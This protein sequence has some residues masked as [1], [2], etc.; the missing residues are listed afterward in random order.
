MN[1]QQFLGGIAL[2]SSLACSGSSSSSS[3]ASAANGSL[4]NVLATS[5]EYGSLNVPTNQTLM[6]RFDRALDPNTLE[7]NLRLENAGES[8]PGVFVL[9][10]GN[11]EATFFP[12][13]AAN[14]EKGKTYQILVTPGVR[15]SSGAS[16]GIDAIVPFQTEPK[17]EAFSYPANNAISVATNAKLAIRFPRAVDPNSV[18]PNTVYL[19]KSN[20][21][22]SGEL[23]LQWQNRV[24]LFRPDSNLQGNSVYTLHVVGGVNGVLSM[25]GESLTSSLHSSFQ[26]SLFEDSTAP[27]ISVT[28]RDIP[29]SMNSNLKIPP[30]GSEIDLDFGDGYWGIIQP[31]SL[32]LNANVDLGSLTAGSN[33]LDSLPIL[34]FSANKLRV[35]IPSEYAIAGSTAQFSARVKD[36][37]ENTSSDASF[38]CTITQS[39]NAIVP[40]EK[41]QICWVRFDLNRDGSTKQ[42]FEED[43]IAY[44]LISASN[45]LGK[46][47]A[48][49][50][51]IEE[52]VIDKANAFFQQT[53]WGRVVFT[54]T[55]PSS[56]QYMKMAM[57]G[58]DPSSSS[59]ELD[60]Q[61]TGVLGRAF[62]DSLNQNFR[63]DDSLSNPPLGVFPREMFRAYF[64]GSG[65]S[66]FLFQS[67]FSPLAPSLG[68][69]P[70]GEHAVD[71]TVL[72][73]NF[74]YSTATN[75]AKVRYNQIQT[76]ILRFNK[77]V[78]YLLAHET[79]HAVGLVPD[80]LYGRNYHNFQSSSLDV[81][82][83]N[84]SFTIVASLDVRFRPIDLGYLLHVI[85]N[86]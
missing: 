17:F 54:P 12:E 9:S 86:Q 67:T 19:E 28:V 69:T 26:T 27:Q 80:N 35:R 16:V 81:M 53:S 8:V 31:G 59:E 78:G 49:R 66:D 6:I 39:S 52:G 72:D 11:T 30:F 57:G 41:T 36:L 24:V 15:S 3:S 75:E 85:L 43:L 1:W 18:Q 61:T 7:G 22:V 46:N 73:S 70:I 42:D 48:L 29:L 20:Q 4:L 62:F 25:S 74:N 40:F 84:V 56:T 79:G 5:P 68:G 14:L 58:F 45:P 37:S 55:Q 64:P 13:F 60:G 83:P 51:Q 44:G 76:A 32:E 33:L 10:E 38:S 2:L 65:F 77:V 21:L 34:Q 82:G 71:A 47:A 63:D 50:A 23:E